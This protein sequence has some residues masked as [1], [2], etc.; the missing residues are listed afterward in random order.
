MSCPLFLVSLNDPFCAIQDSFLKMNQF[1][2][3]SFLHDT[4]LFSSET[5]GGSLGARKRVFLSFDS[6]L[7]PE[8]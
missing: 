3:L 2:C 4:S 6:L 7:G 5:L 8:I 1:F